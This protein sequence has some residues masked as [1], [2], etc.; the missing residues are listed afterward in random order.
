VTAN[1][2]KEFE[3]RRM[4]A[5]TAAFNL[6]DIKNGANQRVLERCV[7]LG[8]GVGLCLCAFAIRCL[9]THSHAL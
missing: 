9:P 3:A 2:K 8:L 1:T 7:G 6:L 5:L 4:V